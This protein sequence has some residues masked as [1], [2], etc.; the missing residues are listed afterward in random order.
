MISGDGKQVRDV[1]HAADLIQVYLQ[2][3]D[4]IDRTAG[5]IYNIG[6]GRENSLSLI[7]LFAILSQ[8]IG[9]PLPFRTQ[10]W[11]VA[12]QKVFVADYR[13][14]TADFGWSPQVDHRNGLAEALAWTRELLAA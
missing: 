14:A 1:L 5:K 12:D 11:R 13:R 6:G 3:A 8:S 10:G 2:A 4:N 9:A 7:E